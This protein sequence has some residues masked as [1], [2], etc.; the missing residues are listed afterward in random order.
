M[1]CIAELV[2]K[3]KVWSCTRINF[4]FSPFPFI[5]FLSLSPSFLFSPPPSLRLRSRLPCGVKVPKSAV[6]NGLVHRWARN[7]SAH[8]SLRELRQSGH[9][10]IVGKLPLETRLLPTKLGRMGGRHMLPVSVARRERVNKTDIF[11]A[12]MPLV[13]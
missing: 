3:R 6:D 12:A 1:H 2:A 7:S 8:T 13:K 10:G 9:V 11:T 5:F 4:S